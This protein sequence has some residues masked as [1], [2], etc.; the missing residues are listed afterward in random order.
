MLGLPE[1]HHASLPEY[2]LLTYG[3]QLDAYY[4]Y[5]E[6]LVCQ[7]YNLDGSPLALIT[8]TAVMYRPDP[9]R[10][11][12]GGPQSVGECTSV[13]DS[14]GTPRRAEPRAIPSPGSLVSQDLGILLFR[15]HPTLGNLT[16]WLWCKPLPLT[17]PQYTST[18]ASVPGEM[19]PHPSLGH[20]SALGE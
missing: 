9:L 4:R 10:K 7:M 14:F 17:A 20:P 13:S 12:P 5:L 2:Y 6:D 18:R 16:R 3:L 15:W 1:P 8:L 11:S 19:V